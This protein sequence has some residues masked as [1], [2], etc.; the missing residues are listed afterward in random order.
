[1]HASSD[2]PT[3]GSPNSSSSC[4]SASALRLRSLPAAAPRRTC[5]VHSTAAAR[6]CASAAASRARGSSRERTAGRHAAAP[7]MVQQDSMRQRAEGSRIA[8]VGRLCQ[9]ANREVLGLCSA[10]QYMSLLLVLGAVELLSATRLGAPAPVQVPAP[11][12][13]V[14][15]AAGGPPAPGLP[16][17]VPRTWDE[18]GAAPSTASST[19]VPHQCVLGHTSRTYSSGQRRMALAISTLGVPWQAGSPFPGRGLPAG[20]VGAQWHQEPPHVGLHQQLHPEPRCGSQRQR[21]RQPSP[22]HMRACAAALDLLG[23]IHL[24]LLDL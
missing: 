14:G 10:C 21:R 23:R 8:C 4:G 6:P 15:L 11:A 5:A 24:Q 19:F 20:E 3:A 9:I 22:A 17:A 1:M 18:H 2:W 16:R 13:A 12:A 7:T